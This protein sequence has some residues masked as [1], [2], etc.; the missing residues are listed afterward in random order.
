MHSP[1]HNRGEP[2][3]QGRPVHLANAAQG[4]AGGNVVDRMARVINERIGE[5]G[6]ATRQDLLDEGF[7]VTAIVFNEDAARTHAAHLRGGDV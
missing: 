7:S 5:N 4:V 3:R 2:P 6:C 1:T